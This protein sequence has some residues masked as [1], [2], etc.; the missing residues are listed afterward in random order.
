MKPSRLTTFAAFASLASA[1]TLSAQGVISYTPGVRHYHL[2]SVINRTQEVQGQKMEFKIT[3]EQQVSLS[4]AP[5]GKDTLD[6]ALTLDSTSLTSDRPELQLPDVSQ[7]KGTRVSG[8]MSRSGKVFH[9]VS[10]KSPTD[11]DTKSLV[12]GMTRFLIA[13]PPNAKVGTS[14]VDTTTSTVQRDGAQLDMRTI[15]TSTI[16]GDTVYEGQKAWRVQR[17]L[18]LS[19]H[20][21]QS[22]QGQNWKVDGDGTGS[23]MYYVSAAGVYL[24]SD[25]MQ[26]MN[27][28]VAPPSGG[29]AIPVEQVV[30][31]KVELLGTGS[32]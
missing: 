28:K 6:F 21:T 25:A 12:E 11:D 20:G 29:D 26:S 32:Q 30:T 7:M 27:M 14:W 5:H 17:K 9:F 13:P 16:L 19:L 31:S 24:G 15:T 1:M 10:N 18:I 4:L 2:V 23:G 3:N 22:Q 8:A